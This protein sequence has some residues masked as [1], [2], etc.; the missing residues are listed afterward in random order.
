METKLKIGVLSLQGAV[1]E[2]IT[3]LNKLH[4]QALMVK[5]NK[6]LKDIDGL[7]IP[8][9]ES[10]T[11]GKLM[12]EREMIKTIKARVKAGMGI[13]GT[14]AGLVL[15]AKNVV[16]NIQPLLSLMDIKVKRNAFGSQI[17]SFETDLNIPEISS[18]SFKAVFI[19]APVILNSGD[20]VETLAAYKDQKV[21]ARQNKILVSSFHPELT[22]D[23]RLHMYFLKLLK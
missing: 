17:F 19:R 15:M 22:D 14:C 2:H 10:T 23:L 18:N 16:D 1:N 20:N 21:L 3:I 9:G 7:I 4:C 6:H 13:F 12:R 8:G 11:I 5:N